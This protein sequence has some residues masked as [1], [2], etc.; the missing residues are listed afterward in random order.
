MNGDKECSMLTPIK[1][2]RSIYIMAASASTAE[3]QFNRPLDLHEDEAASLVADI[4]AVCPNLLNTMEGNTSRCRLSVFGF[5]KGRHILK[6]LALNSN[7][8]IQVRSGS[9]PDRSV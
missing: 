2:V 7:I 5:I 8:I 3:V 6:N 1:E 9:M 4:T